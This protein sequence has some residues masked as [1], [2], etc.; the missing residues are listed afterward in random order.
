MTLIVPEIPFCGRT[1][2]AQQLCKSGKL[3]FLDSDAP[4][5]KS[6]EAQC[7]QLNNSYGL[8]DF[9]SFDVVYGEFPITRYQKATYRYAVL[10]RDPFERL[11]A[12]YN[13]MLSRFEQ[14]LQQAPE[15]AIAAERILTDE[16]YGFAQWVNALRNHL[17]FKAYLDYRAPDQF[18]LIGLPERYQSY[19]ERLSKLIGTEV[20]PALGDEYEVGKLPKMSVADERFI[21]NILEPE[22]EWFYQA[23][24]A[25]A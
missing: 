16:K 25:A 19:C 11:V 5:K 3:V 20:D 21:K 7:Q 2:T 14:K 23:H 15:E 12:Q 24:R 22:Y 10:I 1:G 4:P 17:P 9:S 18:A 6:R 13:Q 8:L